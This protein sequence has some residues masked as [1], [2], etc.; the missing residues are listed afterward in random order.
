LERKKKKKFAT[1]VRERTAVKAR[2]KDETKR[3]SEKKKRRDSDPLS[4]YNTTERKWGQE[5]KKRSTFIF[6]F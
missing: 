5:K 4:F 3:V 2:R 6:V 1:K